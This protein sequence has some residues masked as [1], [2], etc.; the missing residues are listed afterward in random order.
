LQDHEWS[1]E[2]AGV[3]I[4]SHGKIAQDRPF[5][6]DVKG[7][8]ILSRYMYGVIEADWLDELP[9]DVVSTDRRSIDWSTDDTAAFHQW[10]ASKAVEWL[11]SYRKWREG[12]PKGE[13]V[14]KI[15]ELN[16][17]LTAPEEEALADLLS[18][19]FTDLGNNE[20]AKS[21]TT[22]KITSAWTHAPTRQLTQSIWK[23]VF[24]NRQ[25]TPDAFAALIEQL[26]KSLVPEAMGLAVT[27]AQRIN[28]ITCLHEIIVK[29][30]NETHLQK[31]IEKF[32]WLLDPSNDLLSANT[33]IR[34]IVTEK[35]KPNPDNGGWSLS[36]P[37]GTRRPDFVFLS[38]PGMKR[39]IVIYELKGPECDKALQPA[40]FDQLQ[41]YIRIISRIYTNLKVTGILVGHEDGGLDKEGDKRITIRLWSEI[42]HQA[43]HLHVSYLE[44]LL[45]VSQPDAD[46]TRMK[47]IA[48][49]GGDETMELLR[50]YANNKLLETSE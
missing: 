33:T 38:D 46:D 17:K 43:R 19:V 32:P 44:A 47:Q 29:E 30:K 25:Y 36:T 5:F 40:E 21:K 18:E 34:R 7:K 31:L 1:I 26:R 20:E 24:S 49:F 28:A 35:H 11:E 27:M 42:L 37:D 45:R 12:R 3:G 41:D 2:N 50:R 16:N 4:Y 9:H 48:D 15:R 8:E 23:E 13:I 14:K 22:E 39:E 10:G 6:F